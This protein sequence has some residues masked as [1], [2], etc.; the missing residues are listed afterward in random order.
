MERENSGGYHIRS[1]NLGPAPRVGTL[2][3]KPGTHPQ[4]GSRKD[5]S[6]GFWFQVF[7]LRSIELRRGKQVSELIDLNTE[8]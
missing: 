1:T 4:G 2:K 7:L 3:E 6:Q 5:K 8:T